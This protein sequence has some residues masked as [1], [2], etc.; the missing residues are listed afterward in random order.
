MD[1]FLS[2]SSGLSVIGSHIDA[3]PLV[4]LILN[5]YMLIILPFNFNVQI[6]FCF[7]IVLALLSCATITFTLTYGQFIYLFNFLQ[8]F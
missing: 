8:H 3:C 2:Y 5:I 7:V 4:G 6:L 1:A